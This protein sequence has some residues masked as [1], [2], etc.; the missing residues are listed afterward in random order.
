MVKPLSNHLLDDDKESSAYERSRNVNGGGKNVL[1]ASSVEN[2]SSTYS[3]NEHLNSN[4]TYHNS[5][6]PT[7]SR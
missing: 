1:F 7:T 4:S 2:S 3:I 6:T 5:I